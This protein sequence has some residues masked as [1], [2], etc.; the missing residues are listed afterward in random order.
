MKLQLFRPIFQMRVVKWGM[1]LGLLCAFEVTA[2]AYAQSDSSRGRLTM[3]EIQMIGSHN[4]YHIAPEPRLMKIIELAGAEVAQSIDYT[5]PPLAEQLEYGLRQIELDVCADPEGGRFSSPLGFRMLQDEDELPEYVPNRAGALDRPGL[6]IIHEPSFDYATRNE[7][8][9]S[10]LQEIKE[11][12]MMNREHAPILIL[13]ELKERS[14][15]AGGPRLIPFD[16]PQLANVDAEILEVFSREQIITPDQIR[17]ERNS[18]REAV[19]EQGWSLLADARGKVWFALDNEGGVRDR[20]LE[21]H[22]SLRD[23]I[24]FV[25]VG[26][27]HPA[28][29]FR[30]LN[31][32]IAQYQEI[33]KSVEAGLIVRTRA[34]ADTRQARDND[35]R[36]RDQAF[37]SG[38]Q[39][40]STDYWKA[41]PR[42]SSYRVQFPENK[43]YRILQDR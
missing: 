24:M 27:D 14:V 30:K 3:N 39:Y 37:A 35:T 25:S 29:A 21:G 20:Y 26:M 10:A 28:A 32:P 36:R 2:S 33:K 6:K 4:S 15:V 22:P 11:W 12:S 19:M 23:R 8:F 5:H 34:D 9:K 13:V 40:I 1:A 38:A 31:D 7:T 18:L 17:G 16:K 41:D 43:E 42:F